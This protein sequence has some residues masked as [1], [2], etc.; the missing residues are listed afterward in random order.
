MKTEPKMIYNSIIHQIDQSKKIYVCS[1]MNPDADA[2]GS[3]LGLTQ[4]LKSIGKDCLAIHPGDLPQDLS[5]MPLLDTLVAEPLE[6]CD[7]LIAVDTATRERIG[8]VSDAPERAKHSVCIDHHRSNEGYLDINW[9]DPSASST[10]EM[11]FRLIEEWGRPM[12][13]ETA[14]WLYA[15]LVADSGRFLY[16]QTSAYSHHVAAEL[17]KME[18]D[19]MTIHQQL[20]QMMPYGSFS[21]FRR[22]IDR[23]VFYRDHAI[24]ISYSTIADMKEFGTGFE[25]TDIA[26]NF[27]RDIADVEVSVMIKEAENGSTKISLRSKRTLDVSKVAAALG[28]GGHLRAA[29]GTVNAP[30]EEARTLVLQ[31]IESFWDA[32]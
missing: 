8:G 10:A 25:S 2:L 7:L 30:I 23:A 15:G 24:V 3:M 14:Q 28:G 11:I 29:G 17:M 19:W 20:F 31:T 18:I 12:P 5:F 22:L 9:I 6:P 21:L 16:N 13:K 26:M 32:R 27:L 4:F 1:H